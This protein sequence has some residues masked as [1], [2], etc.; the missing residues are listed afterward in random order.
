[1]GVLKAQMVHHLGR[2]RGGGGQTTTRGHV[3]QR[4]GR[5]RPVAPRRGL[6]GA[7]PVVRACV[8]QGPRV[9][10]GGPE[11]DTA[12]AL[13]ERLTRHGVSEEVVNAALDAGAQR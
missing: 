7:Q 13:V 10:L 9:E 3:K 12:A 2:R 4:L 11:H 5:N 6:S 1:M 8:G